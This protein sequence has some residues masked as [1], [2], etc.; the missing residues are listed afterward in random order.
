MLNGAFYIE[1]QSEE[2]LAGLGNGS[3]AYQD[4][5]GVAYSPTE[6]SHVAVGFYD[7]GGKVDAKPVGRRVSVYGY[8]EREK[9][10]YISLMA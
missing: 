3:T 1:W 7:A 10:Y 6:S 2:K 8:G 5:A 9:D 4:L